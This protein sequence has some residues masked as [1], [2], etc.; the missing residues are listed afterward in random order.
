MM[1]NCNTP[2][3]VCRHTMNIYTLKLS[4]L[5]GDIEE[6][7]NIIENCELSTT[8]NAIILNTLFTACE[9]GHLEIA[10]ILIDHIS[11]ISKYTV[12]KITNY[13]HV[14]IVDYL[15]N[16]HQYIDEDFL[17]A[18]FRL[19]C[20]KGYTDIVK[21]F[22]DYS[23]DND[24]AN[25]NTMQH[26][27]YYGNLDV[28]K[29][30][31]ISG[32]FIPTENLFN[33]IGGHIEIIKYMI[34]CPS[35]TCRDLLIGAC[36]TRHLNVIRYLIEDEKTDTTDIVQCMLINMESKIYFNVVEYLTTRFSNHVEWYKLARIAIEKNKVKVFKYLIEQ[37][38]SE[39]YD[40]HIP[41]INF[42][43][44]HCYGALKIL[45]SYIT[46]DDKKT[47]RI[48]YNQYFV[49]AC[50]N[51]D[52]GIVKILVEDFDVDVRFNNNEALRKTCCT[53]NL[54][55]VKF[56]VNECNAWIH[57]NNNEPFRNACKICC[58]DIVNFLIDSGADSS[59]GIHINNDELLQ[60]VVKNNTYDSKFIH[61]QTE[62]LK[63]LIKSGADIH[64]N[65]E[66]ALIATLRSPR[67]IDLT[68]V[69][70]DAGA[71]IAVNN[72]HHLKNLSNITNY[73]TTII[74]I[75]NLDDGKNNLMS[76]IDKYCLMHAPVL[77]YLIHT[78]GDCYLLPPGYLRP[79]FR[80]LQNA[81]CK[82]II[83]DVEILSLPLVLVE[84]IGEYI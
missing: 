52:F 6:I 64:V 38:P 69:L 33:C 13:G 72:Y 57:A 67:L 63:I 45:K 46:D 78:I 3:S 66:A 82:K 29:I 23:N 55:I 62:I 42:A 48:L 25:D 20:S 74:Y 58:L 36:K 30:L 16:R 8:N 71:D 44:R 11:D 22:I 77:D 39:I 76:H 37:A 2:Q 50:V 54:E 61:Q 34:E 15:V 79:K 5:E 24:K 31:H 28:V 81:E 59:A 60:F 35:N 27:L 49:R 21:M 47:N 12:L 51:N 32:K 26:A 18:A 84:L 1:N 80:S 70:I 19:A 7:K 83:K 43:A 14:S 56:L 10:K 41:L 68:K 65:D 73:Y 4:C 9:K 40:N 17:D 53:R 75:C